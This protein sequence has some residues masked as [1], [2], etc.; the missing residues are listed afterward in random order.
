MIAQGKARVAHNKREALPEGQL[1]D[2]EGRPSTDPAYAVHAPYGALRAFGE[3][4]GYGLALVC[5]I[6]GGALA[7]G[8]TQRQP[9]DGRRRVHNGMLTIIFDPARLADE[10]VFEREMKG[11]LEWVTASPRQQGHDRVRV[12]GEPEREY[13]AKRLADGVPVD[14]NTW[15]ELLATC[16]LLNLNRAEFGRLAGVI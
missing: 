15:K 9:A 16:D 4:K 5:E 14:E 1:I 8:M 13:R 3:H 10:S 11:F 12:A 6:L 2:H 7:G